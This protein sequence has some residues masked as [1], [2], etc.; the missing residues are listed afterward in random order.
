VVITNKWDEM[1][2]EAVP[3]RI[4]CTEKRRLNAVKEQNVDFMY[5]EAL[6]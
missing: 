4:I 6:D 2:L 5:F 3:S 1:F